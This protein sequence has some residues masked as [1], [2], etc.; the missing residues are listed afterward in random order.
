MCPCVALNESSSRSR[1]SKRL[2]Y[3]TAL[4]F[5]ECFVAKKEESERDCPDC[6]VTHP[7]LSRAWRHSR[8]RLSL[9]CAS[10]ANSAATR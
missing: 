5:R 10:Q 1:V 2:P 7:C 6:Q 9:A 4:R 3:I 8:E